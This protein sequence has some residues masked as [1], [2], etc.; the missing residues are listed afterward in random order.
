MTARHRVNEGADRV[1]LL[2]EKL[3]GDLVGLPRCTGDEDSWM[4]KHGTRGSDAESLIHA[5][6]K[7]IAADTRDTE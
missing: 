1:A 5:P 6:S 2:Q 4:T 7:Y 3:R